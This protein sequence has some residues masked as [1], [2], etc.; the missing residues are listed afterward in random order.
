MTVQSSAQQTLYDALL[1]HLR[2][3]PAA[4]APARRAAAL[5][6]REL[7]G[8]CDRL[9]V[10]WLQ[11]PQDRR[12]RRTG[13]G[14]WPAVTVRVV[15]AARGA[16]QA[17]PVGLAAVRLQVDVWSRRKLAD[18]V[19]AGDALRRALDGHRGALGRRRVDRIALDDEQDSHEADS[20]RR[21]W[22]RRQDYRVWMVEG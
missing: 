21:M 10:W 15:S 1:D 9:R 3:P 2:E 7:V 13:P 5:E 4:L 20:A 14:R 8:G 22:R 18:V 6:L 17:G 19:A 16:T 12:A 11:L